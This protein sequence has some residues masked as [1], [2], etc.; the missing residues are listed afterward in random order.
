MAT[1]TDTAPEP[2]ESEPAASWPVA[3]NPAIL[4]CRNAWAAAYE[5]VLS[6]GKSDFSAELKGREAYREAMPPLS[7]SRNIRNF[8]A[9]AAHG[10]LIGA[11]ESKHATSLLYAAQVASSTAKRAAK[12][13]PSKLLPTQNRA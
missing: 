9:C 11:I 8:I 3:S 5:E 2:E 6:E 4:A 7:G 1:T 10:L 13:R 12:S